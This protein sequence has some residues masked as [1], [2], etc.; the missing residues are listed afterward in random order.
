MTDDLI[1]GWPVSREGRIDIVAANNRS[2]AILALSVDCPSTIFRKS[3]ASSDDTDD[4]N[5]PLID[6]IASHQIG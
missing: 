3:K 1:S 4:G 6:D 2:S 5:Y